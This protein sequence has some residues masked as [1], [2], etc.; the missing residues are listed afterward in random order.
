MAQHGTVR[1]EDSAPKSLRFPVVSEGAEY[2]VM[3]HLMRRN[4]LKA[5]G[6]MV[7][8]TRLFTI[9][10]DMDRASGQSVCVSPSPGSANIRGRPVYVRGGEHCGHVL[11]VGTW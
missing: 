6:Q 7:V 10:G 1:T 2:L 9:D 11:G 4:I 3:G 8:Q 5:N